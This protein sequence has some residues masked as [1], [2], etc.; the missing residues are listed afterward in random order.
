MMK[1]R[2]E[3]LSQM[4]GVGVAAAI[5][6]TASASNPPPKDNP[7]SHGIVQTVQGPIDAAKLGF[8]LPHEHICVSSPGFWQTWPEF[9]GGRS[10]FV[11]RWSTN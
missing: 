6:H 8:T 5:A 7:R 10:A 2:R 11:N 9:F 4:T 1:T 3:F